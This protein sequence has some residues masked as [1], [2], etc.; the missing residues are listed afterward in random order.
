MARRRFVIRPK[1]GKK[2]KIIY[3]AKG[4]EGTFSTRKKAMVAVRIFHKSGRKTPLK[5]IRRK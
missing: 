1:V 3:T 2:K 4:Y 5:I